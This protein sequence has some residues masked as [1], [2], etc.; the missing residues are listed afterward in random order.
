MGARSNHAQ[1][2][3]RPVVLHGTA[4][5]LLIDR[6]SSS[7]LDMAKRMDRRADA[8]ITNA[9]HVQTRSFILTGASL[10]SVL[11]GHLGEANPDGANIATQHVAAVQ[12]LPSPDRIIETLKVD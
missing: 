6:D 8:Q 1:E 7:T 5:Y 3:V 9:L 12:S 11:D 2:K 10:L 4:E